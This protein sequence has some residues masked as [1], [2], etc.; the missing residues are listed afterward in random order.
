MS[1][2][3]NKSK[4]VWLTRAYVADHHLDHWHPMHRDQRLGQIIACFYKTTSTPGNWQD[5]IQHSFTSPVQ[6]VRLRSYKYFHVLRSS[7]AMHLLAR[8]RIDTHTL[9]H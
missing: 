8:N 1:L 3:R 6:N 2:Q 4:M 7:Q 5:N 9:T